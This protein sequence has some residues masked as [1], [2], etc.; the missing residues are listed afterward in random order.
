MKR[1][2]LTTALLAGLTGTVGIA[3]M[4]NAVNINPDGLGETL[5]YPYYTVRAGTDTLISVVNTSMTEVK[6]VKVRFLEG[7]NSQEVLDFNLYLSP[8]DVWTAAVVDDGTAARMFTEDVS[9]TVPGIPAE[10]VQF[11]SFAFAGDSGNQTLDRTRE[12]YLEIIEMGVV[13]NAT[14]A[15]AATHPVTCSILTAS[16]NGGTWSASPN[17]GITE[18]TGGLFGGASLINVEGGFDAAYNADAL[19]AFSA[20]PLHTQPGSL[21]PS[22]N[23][24]NPP[25]SNVFNNGTVV[26]S[27][28]DEGVDA[29]SA[30]YMHNFIMNEYILD[31]ATLSGTD[32]VTTFPTKRF[33]VGRADV[34]PAVDL[35]HDNPFTTPFANGVACEP[36]SLNLY[37]REETTT[38]QPLDFSPLPPVGGN[39]LCWEVTIITFN[40]S[41]VLSSI[42]SENISSPFENG[43]LRLGFQDPDHRMDSLDGDQYNGL[44]A[45]GFQVQTFNNSTLEVD[46]ETVLS[47]YAGLFKHRATRDITAS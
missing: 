26:T 27:T 4:S 19:D 28:W 36:I 2:T 24:A 29:V 14:F 47:N 7:E 46:G 33:Y 18:P 35:G 9:C 25:V 10:G 21:N 20:T 45:T 30:V 3:N 23:A 6:A 41:N 34:D 43:W 40:N 17:F 5:I 39:A 12:G 8:N 38:E 42:L 44:P 13:T 16:W 1:K 32:W 37:D 15:A 11:R 22:L 31:Q